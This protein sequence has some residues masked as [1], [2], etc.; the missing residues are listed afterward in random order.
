MKRLFLVLALMFSASLPAQAPTA[1]PL[2][3]EPRHHF[4]FENDYVRVFRV[5]VPPHDATLLHQHDVPYL[6]IS[7]GPADVI[8]A[9]QDKP[10]ARLV[11]A[12]GQVGYSRGGFAHIARTDAGSPFNNVTI[13]LLKPQ[14][15]PHNLCVRVIEGPFGDCQVHSTHSDIIQRKTVPAFETS[16]M[17]LERVQIGKLDISLQSMRKFPRLL[18]ALTGMVLHV[19]IGAQQSE[20]LHPGDVVWLPGNVQSGISTAPGFLM[21]SNYLLLNFEEKGASAK[22]GKH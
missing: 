6:Y 7:L 13:E 1:V 18:V 19:E 20:L 3:E 17:R 14:G 11:M 22:P 15:E 9:V 16:A 2:R 8:N 12:D 5:S 10:E 21:G 4:V